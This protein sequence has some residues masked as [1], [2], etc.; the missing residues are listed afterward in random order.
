MTPTMGVVLRVVQPLPPDLDLTRASFDEREIELAFA[1][2]LAITRPK[3]H[4]GIYVSA[5]AAT[6]VCAITYLKQFRYTAAR[7]P[8]TAPPSPDLNCQH[9]S[10]LHT[11][12]PTNLDSTT[13][14]TASR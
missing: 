3:K 12:H 8:A 9:L 6:S 4:S 2:S 5:A 14:P 13:L 11:S 1:H 10:G 7:L